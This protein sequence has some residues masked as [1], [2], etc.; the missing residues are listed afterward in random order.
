MREVVRRDER[1][2][3]GDRIKESDGEG[4][5]RGGEGIGVG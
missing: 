4:S 1:R 3:G 2:G 5:E